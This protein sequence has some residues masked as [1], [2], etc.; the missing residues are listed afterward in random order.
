[1]GLPDLPPLVSVP[2]AATGIIAPEVLAARL[3]ECESQGWVP[4]EADFHQALL[5]LP[6]DCG[7][8]DT[9]GFTSD[10]GRR[11]AAWV[12]GDRVEVPAIRLP[13]AGEI[14]R[15][16]YRAA[17]PASVP[18]P[19]YDTLPK[20]LLELVPDA[21]TEVER[22]SDRSDWDVCWPAIL[23]A[24]PDLPA[25][26]VVGGGGWWS[27][28]P[29]VESAILL[30]ELDDPVHAGTHF[31]IAARLLHE[32][33]AMR[34]SGID[35]ILVLAARGLLDPRRLAVAL[36]ARLPVITSGLRTLVPMLRDLA[37]GGAAGQAWETIAAL[38]PE[39]LPPAFPKMMAGTADLLALGSELARALTVREPIAEVTAL[40]EKGGGVAADAARRLAG[41]LAAG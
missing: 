41:V 23:P 33:A 40:A 19:A 12:A 24:H 16:V 29:S 13:V 39:I 14:R 21:W 31:V 25:L 17:A 36:A 38:L 6:A 20:T 2:T 4:L 1:L 30:A 35:A 34:A 37:D 8:V 5:R 22:Q 32:Q 9:T 7:G 26:A 18:P 15:P 3:R 27:V 28:Q 11:F 10:A